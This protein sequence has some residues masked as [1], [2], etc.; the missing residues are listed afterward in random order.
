MNQQEEADSN[1]KILSDDEID[2]LLDNVEKDG[3]EI[4]LPES[5]ERIANFIK[6]L[7][8]VSTD[9]DH[10]PTEFAH[11][12]TLIAIHLERGLPHIVSAL[13]ESI[14]ATATEMNDKLIADVDPFAPITS[15]LPELESALQSGKLQEI[16]A[17]L[18]VKLI[19]S[20]AISGKIYDVLKEAMQPAFYQIIQKN[21][22]LIEDIVLLDDR[23]IQLLLQRIELIDLVYALKGLDEQVVEKVL[24][25]MPK[26]ASVRLQ[27]EM[28]FMGPVRLSDVQAKQTSICEQILEMEKEGVISIARAGDEEV[29]V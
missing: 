7:Q 21:R 25:N 27:E 14:V 2:A 1:A 24:R 4:P 13:P 20:L 19:D 28:E 23:A 26:E 12:L 18:L 22:F 11:V 5:A 15:I 17:G 9:T 8:E 10:I 3:K 6:L 16:G 29:L